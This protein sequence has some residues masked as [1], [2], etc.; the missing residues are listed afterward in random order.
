M[1]KICFITTIPGTLRAF[2]LETA[3]YLHEKGE[4]D[5][6][7]ICDYDENFKN[8]L[9]E[10]ITYI[11]IQMSRGINI[12]GFKAV[13]EMYKVFKKDKYDIVQYSTP[14]ASFYAAIAAKMANIKVRLYCQWG[15]VYVGFRGIK[16]NIFKITEKIVCKLSTWIEPDSYGNMQ[17]SHNEGLYKKNKSS[18][19]WNGSASGVNM[20]RFDIDRKNEWR[21]EIRQKYSIDS[22]TF[23]FG[24][25][26]RITGDKGINE[27]L[28]ASREFFCTKP[29]SRLLIIGNT[30]NTDSINEKLYNWSLG[31]KKVI[32]C[33]R[34]SEVE[35]YFSAMDVFVLPSYREGFGNVVIEAE[36][37]GISVIVSDIP[38]PTDGM[39]EGKT[40]VI[41]KKEDV[42]SLFEAL[43]FLNSNPDICKE[44]GEEGY[45]F[46][47]K[48]FEA[49]KLKKYILEDRN[50]LLAEV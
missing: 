48:S 47:S 1:K 3:K 50:K 12:N 33:G 37:M 32:Y 27:L 22:N 10:Y 40:G 26:G 28:E 15:I 49:K 36:A 35:K 13:F 24:F 21:R 2:I 45:Y 34:T 41:I 20:E 9:P 19:V 17:F 42:A 18:V 29:N 14:N 25:V 23:V 39:V 7:F 44:M 38:G 43:L 16:K 6:T 8:S 30:E 11:P 5:I 4:Y 31:E 46:V